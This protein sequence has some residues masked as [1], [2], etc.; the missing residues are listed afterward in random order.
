MQPVRQIKCKYAV[1]QLKVPRGSPPKFQRGQ[2]LARFTF[3]TPISRD[4]Q[5]FLFD[6]VRRRKVILRDIKPTD[7]SRIDQFWSKLGDYN[8]ITNQSLH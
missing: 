2:E 7:N 6:G 5:V 4:P 1:K 8:L 3:E